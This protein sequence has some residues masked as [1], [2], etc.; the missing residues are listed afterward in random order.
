[1]EEAKNGF[2]GE[3]LHE[4]ER[5]VN[6]LNRESFDITLSTDKLYYQK[7]INMNEF[8]NIIPFV[9]GDK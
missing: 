7:F 5:V 6:A 2:Y 9:K 3:K 4:I 1:M 8:I